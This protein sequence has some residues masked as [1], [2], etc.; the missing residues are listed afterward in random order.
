MVRCRQELVL[1]QSLLYQALL[2]HLA[3]IATE[4]EIETIT[5][6]T[7]HTGTVVAQVGQSG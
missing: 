6:D 7:D 3:D 2:N 5:G 1:F 4:Q